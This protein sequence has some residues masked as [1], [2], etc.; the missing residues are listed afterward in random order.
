MGPVI[1]GGRKGYSDPGYLSKFF[2]QVKSLF[3][4]QKNSS[5][6]FRASRAVGQGHGWC[7]DSAIQDAGD[8]GSEVHSEV[9]EQGLIVQNCAPTQSMKL[10]HMHSAYAQTHT[11]T[12][13]EQITLLKGPGGIKY[14]T[15]VSLKHETFVSLVL[16]NAFQSLYWQDCRCGEALKS[17][18][19]AAFRVPCSSAQWL[20]PVWPFTQLAPLLDLLP[21]QLCARVLSSSS[22]ELLSTS[23]RSSLDT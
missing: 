2:H 13:T 5:Q 23:L 6:E 12:L 4:L 7:G 1:P 18:L 21:A 10:V 15:A 22:S 8:T 9:T 20:P 11:Q 3:L 16:L 14:K 19:P 17:G